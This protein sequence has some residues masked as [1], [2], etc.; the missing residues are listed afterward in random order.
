MA[1]EIKT[2]TIAKDTSLQ[3]LGIGA[4]S[5]GLALAQSSGNFLTGIVVTIVG[6]GI[7]ALYTKG[8]IGRE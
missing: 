6:V 8:Y 7:L 5:S 2:P 3:F 4:V 1:D